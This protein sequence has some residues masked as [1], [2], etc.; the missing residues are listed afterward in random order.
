MV[1]VTVT[2]TVTVMA[3]VRRRSLPRAMMTAGS[4]AGTWGSIG[5]TSSI[6]WMQDI[7]NAI[8]SWKELGVPNRQEKEQ[9]KAKEKEQKEEI[10]HGEEQEKG[11][12]LPFVHVLKQLPNADKTVHSG[13]D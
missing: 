2:V 11:Q 10:L 5:R 6:T 3:M 7:I 1:T 12:N 8:M 13:Q 9:K 4:L